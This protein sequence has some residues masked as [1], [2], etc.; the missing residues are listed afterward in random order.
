M[1]MI[2]AVVRRLREAFPHC[3]I[4]LRADS[5]LALPEVPHRS[6]LAP[7]KLLLRAIAAFYRREDALC[8]KCLAAIE[9]DAAA[10]RLAPALRALMGQAPAL[11]PATNR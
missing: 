10:A 6:P 4:E 1:A 11:T 9:P 8:E 3:R 7:W 5:A 2:K